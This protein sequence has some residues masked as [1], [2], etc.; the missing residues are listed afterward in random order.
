MFHFQRVEL[1][2][3]RARES[4]EKPKSYPH[5]VTMHMALEPGTPKVIDLTQAFA[6][7]SFVMFMTSTATSAD[8]Y[9]PNPFTVQ[10]DAGSVVTVE[11]MLVLNLN[12]RPTNLTLAAAGTASVDLVVQLAGQ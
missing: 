7:G 6:A 1:H 5:H 10:I 11:D 2:F 8:P 4:Y 12:E 3:D 9:T